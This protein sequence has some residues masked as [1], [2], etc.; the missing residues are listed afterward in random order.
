MWIQWFGNLES[1]GGLEVQE[2]GMQFDTDCQW[3]TG[4]RSYIVCLACYQVLLYSL[5]GYSKQAPH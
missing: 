2:Y 4:M 3:W 5:A 1:Q